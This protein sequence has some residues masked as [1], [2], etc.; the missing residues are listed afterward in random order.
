[1]IQICVLASGSKGNAIYI[2]HEQTAVLIDAG[3]SGVQL[4]ERLRSRGLAAQDLNA[5]IVSHEHVD[6]IQGVGIFSRRY[7]LPVYINQ[8]TFTAAENRLGRLHGV[9]HFDRGDPFTINTLTIHPFSISHDAADPVGFTIEMNGTK[10]GVATDLGVGT[11]L[12]AHH[13]KGCRLMILE[14][15]H[16]VKMLE[17][18]PYPWEL[19]QRVR[20]RVGH[21]SNEDSRNLLG[22]VLDECVEHVIIAHLSETN[23]RPEKALAV[24]GEALSNHPARLS[25]APQHVA[26]ELITLSD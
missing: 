16:D 11:R 2:R 17:E 12:V 25:F 23:N 5:V 15:N 22:D 14:A 10:I 18:G 8:P 26:G 19:K 21:L 7:G 20:S 24:V 3:L 6:H 13:M 9:E 4:E 1:M